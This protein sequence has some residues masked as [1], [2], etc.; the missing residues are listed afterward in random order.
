MFSQQINIPGSASEAT[1]R[2]AWYEIDLTAIQH[3]FRQLRKCLPQ[4]VKIYACL[5][6]NGYGCGAA[7]M[8]AALE[9]EGV[10]GF[11]VAS[12]LDAIDI[13]A[14]GVTRPILLYPGAIPTA[15]STIETLHLSIS[16]SSIEELD[17]WRASMENIHAFIKVDLGFFR[18]GATPRNAV[19]LLAS[20][21][22]YRN[23]EIEGIYAHL[24]E[25]PGAKVT[26]T[27][28]QLARMRTIL[29]EADD[30]GIRP[31]IAMMSSTEG[32]LRHPEMDL[33]AVDPG[34]LFVGLQ[35]TAD[36]IR[37]LPLRPALKSIAASLVSVKHLDASLGTIPTHLGF[38]PEMILGVVGFGWGDGF[39]RQIPH[40][41]WAIVGGRRVPV[42]PPIHLEHLRVDLTSVPQAQ[43][44]DPVVFLGR[45]GEEQITL[46]GLAA[47]WGTDMI[48]IYANLRDH[49]PRIYT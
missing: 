43:V 22:R 5:K 14:L 38:H 44:G 20:A 30:Q 12:M 34:A 45:Q 15:A 19:G 6:R 17:C 42:L 37:S 24:S 23:V 3:N 40:A 29:A 49:I 18:A 25:L 36:P 21:S 39:P 13:R 41:A 8:A 31:V 2:G 1:L 35:E 26:D 47:S 10:D 27:A 16:I 28:D 4:N 9:S 46:E 48:G 11:A 7:R 32:V 33:D